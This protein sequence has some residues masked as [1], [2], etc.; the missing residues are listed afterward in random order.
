M[1]PDGTSPAQLVQIEADVWDRH[2]RRLLYAEAALLQQGYGHD[3]L[4]AW[5]TAAE[6]DQLDA[7]NVPT[8]P[9]TLHD[10]ATA[11]AVEHRWRD[12]N[13]N[14]V[15]EYSVLT[16]PWAILRPLVS[17]MRCELGDPWDAHP[18]SAV[19]DPLRN[20]MPV[21]TLP[22]LRLIRAGEVD[23]A[24]EAIDALNA[25]LPPR[26]DFPSLPEIEAFMQDYR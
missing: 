10:F 6:L 9:E 4:P 3:P 21:W 22:L 19:G 13:P 25:A 24:Q 20:I 16:F 2:L 26:M 15:R 11:Q 23:T 1:R 12:G 5:A 18:P 8:D 7:P 17:Q 14:G